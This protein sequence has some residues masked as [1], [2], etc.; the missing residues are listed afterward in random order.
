MKIEELADKQGNVN[1]DLKIIFDNVEPKDP[2]G[3]GKLVK[4]VIVANAD[5]VQGDNSPTAFLDL[6]GDNIKFKH[7]DKV[8]ITNAYI[9]KR[10]NGQFW[11]T[12]AKIIEMINNE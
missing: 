6:I 12:N 3:N 5:S 1:I 10:N 7:M 2:F 8:R 9:K 11:I 4:T